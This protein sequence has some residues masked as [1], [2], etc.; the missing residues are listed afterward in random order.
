MTTLLREVVKDMEDMQGDEAIGCRTLPLVLGLRPAKMIAAVLAIF[1][2]AAL[3]MYQRVEWGYQLQRSVVLVF[4]F[5]QLPLL[6]VVYLLWYADKSSDFKYISLIIKLI[7]LFG[8]LYLIYFRSTIQLNE[9]VLQLP[10]LE[11][12][13]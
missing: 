10:V 5:L 8:I 9:P 13:E 3:F 11:M 12:G 6:Y 7:M 4:S 2:V 1:I